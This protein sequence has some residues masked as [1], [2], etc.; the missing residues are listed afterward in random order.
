M[1]EK[2]AE[3]ISGDYDYPIFSIVEEGEVMEKT[4]SY[5]GPITEFLSKLK[6][7]R[8][9]L[10]ALVNAL[11]AGEYYGPYRNGDFFPEDA[12]KK[13]HKTFEQYGHVYKNHVNKDPKK[14]MGKVLFSHY[15]PRMKRVE[16][17]VR[18]EKAHPDVVNIRKG[19]SNGMLPKVSM[20]CKVPFDVCSITG[21]KAKTRSDY[22]EYLLTQMG[23]ILPDGRRVCAINT[24]PR[25][26]DLSIVVIPADPVAA[27]MATFDPE[28]NQLKLASDTLETKEAISDIGMNKAAS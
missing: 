14:S 15:N 23:Q 11:T 18:L 19:I 22:S 24:R 16:V 17:V 3:Y 9:Y 8:G 12:L 5:D 28:G 4:A 1:I 27:F 21:K 26:F 10:Y 20:G 25:F 13:Y 7:E 2:R 6:R